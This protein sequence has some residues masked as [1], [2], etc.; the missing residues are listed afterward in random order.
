[1]LHVFFTCMQVQLYVHKLQIEVSVPISWM[2]SV[3]LP[4]SQF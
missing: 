4:S 2:S 1:M 3:C